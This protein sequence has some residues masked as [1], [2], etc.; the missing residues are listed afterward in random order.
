MRDGC[1]PFDV[2]DHEIFARE[3]VVVGEVVEQPVCEREQ[4]Y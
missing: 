2:L 4:A 1:I 3:F